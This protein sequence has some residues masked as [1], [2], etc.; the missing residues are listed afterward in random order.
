MPAQVISEDQNTIAFLDIYPLAAGHTV[1]IPK[2]HATRITDLPEDLVASVFLTVKR[3]SD[4]I[5]ASL[6][7]DG[8]T[9]GIN[10]GEHAGQGIP[11]LHVHIIPRSKGDKG[12]NVHS[13][14]KNPPQESL[15]S[16]AAKLKLK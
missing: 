11:H 5:H 7:P 13:I 1:V 2:F 9:I 16:I 14:V 10:D 3:V 4:R 15:E 8:L 6:K 12:G